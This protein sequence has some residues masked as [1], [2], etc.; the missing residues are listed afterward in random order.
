MAQ[1]NVY[2]HPSH[3]KF[4]FG[5]GGGGGIGSGGADYTSLQFQS[6]EEQHLHV[7]NMCAVRQIMSKIH[8]PS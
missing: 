3:G 7:R 6:Q 1:L 4:F 2:L 5:R 8:K